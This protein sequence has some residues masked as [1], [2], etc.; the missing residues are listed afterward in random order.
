MNSSM[1]PERVK[2]ELLSSSLDGVINTSGTRRHPLGYRRGLPN[3]TPPN[4]F[5]QVTPPGT[6]II[7]GDGCQYQGSRCIQPSNHPAS[8]RDCNEENCLQECFIYLHGEVDIEIRSFN[9]SLNASW[10]YFKIG[11]RRFSSEPPP[12]GSY[13]GAIRW[14]GEFS[15]TAVGWELC[16]PPAPEAAPPAPSRVPTFLL[17]ILILSA[18]LACL[19][20]TK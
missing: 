14:I 19:G 17:L 13:S 5:L 18:S 7:H 8:R 12:N 6:W 1:P 15:E 16:R 2:E 9:T 4:K 10:N 3:A 11:G 20:I